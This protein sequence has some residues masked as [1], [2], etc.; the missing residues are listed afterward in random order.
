MVWSVKICCYQK[1]GW[2]VNLTKVRETVICH[3]KEIIQI[4]EI[5]SLF[6]FHNGVYVAVELV[7][8]GNAELYIYYQTSFKLSFKASK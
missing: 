5:R 1:H 3:Y 7:N 2:N 4:D 8:K 6:S